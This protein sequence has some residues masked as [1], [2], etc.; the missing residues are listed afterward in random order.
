M[1]SMTQSPIILNE[2]QWYFLSLFYAREKWNELISEI[3]HF[4]Q[5]RQDQFCNCLISFS[6]EKGEHLQVSLVSHSNDNNNYTNDIQTYFQTFLDKYPSINRNPFPYGKAVWGNYPNNS[7]I[8]N[9]FRLPDYSKQH[10]KFHQRTMDIALKI[11]KDD[12]SEDA[13]L[14]FGIYLLTKGLCCIKSQ[15]QKYALSDALYEASVSSPH[16]VYVVKEL[17][18]ELDINEV[19][20]AIESYRNENESDYLPE[21]INWLNEAE[22]F[23]E[24]YNYEKLCTLICE[25]V[26]L[27]GLRQLLILELMNAWYNQR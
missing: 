27:K 2:K 23:L 25:T 19:G 6:V 1:N 20:D 3:N 21:F 7:F 4:Y 12:F 16:F 13:I 10:L 5:E 26:G 22:I 11:L 14:S 17:I 15:E 9:K 24:L 18:N 8:W